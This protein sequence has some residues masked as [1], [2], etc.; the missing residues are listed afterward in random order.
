MFNKWLASGEKLMNFWLSRETV[1][2]KGG[3]EIDTDFYW[4]LPNSKIWFPSAE[5]NLT[6][7]LM[8]VT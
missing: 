2:Q 5:G 8:K 4:V 1:S 6:L 3:M 7:T